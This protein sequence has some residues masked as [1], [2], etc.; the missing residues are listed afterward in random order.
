[1]PRTHSPLRNLRRA[2]TLSQVE[3]ARLLRIAQ[4]TYSKYESGVLVPPEDMQARI[5]AIL[6][7]SVESLWPSRTP[8]GPRRD[9]ARA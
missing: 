2:R 5:A 6:G 4:Q 8:S 7:G 9:E 3:M 1:M